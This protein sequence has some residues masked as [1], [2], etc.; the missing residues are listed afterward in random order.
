[1]IGQAARV[2]ALWLANFDKNECLTREEILSPN[3]GQITQQ[4]KSAYSIS[5]LK[6]NKNNWWWRK[7][8]CW[9]LAIFE[10]HSAIQINQRDIPKHFF[11]HEAKGKTD[12]LKRIE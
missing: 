12:K 11:N 3:Q 7:K 4:T 9:S 8:E 2:L 5:I 1:M 10:L 6:T